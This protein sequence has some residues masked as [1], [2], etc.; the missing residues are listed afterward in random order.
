M[1]DEEMRVWFSFELDRFGEGDGEAVVGIV[2]GLGG[3]EAAGVEERGERCGGEL[4]AVFGV[5]GFAG[6]EVEGEGWAG[7]VG[8]D[9]DALGGGR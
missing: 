9:V 4:V 3:G 1:S 5:D 6:G 7:G 8:G 2:P